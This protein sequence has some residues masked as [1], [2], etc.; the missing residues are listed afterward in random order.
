MR[1]AIDAATLLQVA[2]VGKVIGEEPD[3]SGY[4][5]RVPDSRVAVVSGDELTLTNSECFE[6]CQREVRRSYK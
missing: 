6:L 3:K 5:L 1:T 4:V 2:I